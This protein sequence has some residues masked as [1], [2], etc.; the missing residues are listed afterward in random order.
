MKLSHAWGATQ[1]GRVVVERSDRMW[2]T[3]EGNGKPLQYSCMHAQLYPILFDSM[4]CRPPGSSVYVTLQARTLQWVAILFSRGSS[5]PRNWTQIDHIAG[6]FFTIWATREALTH[7]HSWGKFWTPKYTN[8][9]KNPTAIFEEPGTKVG[10]C[11]YS[12]HTTPPKRWA[13]HLS[14]PSSQTPRPTPTLT[15]YREQACLPFGELTRKRICCVFSLSPAAP[16]A[17]IKSCLNFLTDFQWTFIACGRLRT[18]VD[19]IIPICLCLP[20]TLSL[21]VYLCLCVSVYLIIRIPVGRFSI[22]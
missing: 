13:K 18:L 1:D 7:M 9:L 2:S 14:L 20:K 19:N 17:P 5:Q 12:L 10:Y 3:L 22:I 6:R 8:R 15:P 4:K 21:H 11:A 16:W